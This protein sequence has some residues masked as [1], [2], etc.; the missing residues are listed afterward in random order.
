MSD[1]DRMTDQLD[2]AAELQ[3]E[4]NK[5]GLEQVRQAMTAETHPDF[6]GKHCI[7][8]DEDIPALRLA[9]HRIRC[10]PCQQRKEKKR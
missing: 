9:M 4:F 5:R 2:F 10:T 8:C 1:G 7:D 3:D 6:D